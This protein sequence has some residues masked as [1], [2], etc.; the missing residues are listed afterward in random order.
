MKGIHQ[1]FIQALPTDN[2]YLDPHYVE[3][4]K[5]TFKHRPELLQA[6][7]YGSWDAFEGH[8]QVIKNIWLEEAKMR[9]SHAPVVKRFLVCDP[10]RFGNDE[11]VI[12]YMENAEILWSKIMPHCRTTE[13]SMFLAAQSTQNKLCTVVVESTGGDLGAGVIDELVEMSIPVLTYNPSSASNLKQ[14]MGTDKKGGAKYKPIYHNLRA[15]AWCEAA[16]K[17]SSGI[18]DP[19]HNTM[20]SC[21]N[22]YPILQTQLC[23][24]HYKF[25][26][27]KIL[28]ESKDD[29]KTRLGRSPD[30]GDA[31]IIALWAWDKIEPTEEEEQ[32]TR[33]RRP[34]KKKSPMRF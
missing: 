31:Y 26:T 10:A 4:L 25:R 13:I 12:Y 30:H 14:I 6:Y 2:P 29:I 5:E 33:Y 8:A 1:K 9:V 20:L 19:D 17:L 15:E 27:G 7:L 32:P 16:K 18:L 22:M 24:P 23:T 34:R 3:V 28:I 21:T 11:T